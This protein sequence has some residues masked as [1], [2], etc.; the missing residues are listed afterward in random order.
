MKYD[1]ET[2]KHVAASLLYRASMYRIRGD[3]RAARI[4]QECAD[5]V[6]HM[7]SEDCEVD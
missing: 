1:N 6:L 4:V 7:M 5:S 3:N 2:L